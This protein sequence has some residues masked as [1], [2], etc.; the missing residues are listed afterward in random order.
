MPSRHAAT[1]EENVY[2]ILLGEITHLSCYR[3]LLH[4]QLHYLRR[5]HDADYESPQKRTAISAVTLMGPVY[6]LIILSFVADGRYSALGVTLNNR[7]AGSPGL[8]DGHL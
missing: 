2:F 3:S 4:P 6:S 5:K 7:R 8:V 1:R